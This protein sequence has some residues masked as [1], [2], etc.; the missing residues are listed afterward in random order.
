MRILTVL[1]LTLTI[2]GTA[3]AS[4]KPPNV[5]LITV[6]TLRADHLSSYGYH[7]KT[8]PYIDKLAREGARFERVYTTIP[9][10]GPAHLSLFT[11]RY[12]QE[13]GA[14]RNGVAMGAD[15]P[16][17]AFPQLLRA[18][19]YRNAAFVSA[20]PLTARLTGLDAWFDHYDE[21]LTRKYQLFNSSRWA[22]DVTP[23]A[24]DW[25]KRNS[26]GDKPFFLWVHYFD[27]HSPYDFK[28]HFADLPEN[29]AARAP[30]PDAETRERIRNYDTEV[31]YTDWHIGKL[32]AALDELKIA[33]STLVVLTADHGESLGEHNYVGHGR[34]LF[35]DI[36]RVPL[37][38]RLPG[39]VKPNQ[40]LTAP[41]SSLDVAP[42]IVDLTV[43]KLLAEK[44]TPV[45]FAGRSLTPWLT[46]GERV[47]ARRIYNVTFAGKK[48][49]FPKWLS[50]AWVSER[51]LPLRMSSIDGASKL[52]WSPEEQ[53]LR[54]Y[55]VAA[56]RF[57]RKPRAIAADSEFY[58][59]QT[60][61]L[62]SWFSRTAERA[63][64][65]K[66]STR[67]EEILKSLGYAR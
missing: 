7:L 4:E 56:D 10:T 17:V 42:T 32:L 28:K 14:R 45:P 55:D 48:G 65:E 23:P 36:V 18:A 1:L 62:A 22:E 61:R 19:G 58:R 33:S 39:V 21:N 8:T 3:P 30:S 11:S 34:H 15:N 24:I 31:A 27:P 25:M 26:G 40:T 41:V 12:P 29:G 38:V 47:T 49:F 43:G 35:E 2:T 9:L 63:G 59:D 66:L 52:I 6:D 57:E 60:E 20:W 44:K 5:L 46:K 50:W 54:G 16:P 64:E 13:H 51:E 37:I 53:N 67:D